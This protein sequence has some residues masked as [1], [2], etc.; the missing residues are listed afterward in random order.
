MIQLRPSKAA[1]WSVCAAQ[2]S[3]E[4]RTPEEPPSEEAKEGTCAAWVAD[5]VLR[6]DAHSCA[7][8]IRRSH[9]NGWLVGPEMADYVQGY[10]DLV[11]ADGGLTTTEQFVRLNDF[12]GGTL[13]SSTALASGTLKI[14]DLKYGMQL[15]EIFDNPQLL[16]YGGAEYKRLTEAGHVITAIELA[17]YQPRAFHH[18]GIYRPWRLTPQELWDH[19]VRLAT[20][21]QRCQESVPVATAGR[22]CALHHCRAR[23]SCQAFISSTYNAASVLAESTAQRQMTAK[24]LADFWLFLETAEKL[25]KSAKSAA[26]TEAETRMRKGE[27]VPGLFLKPR[28][29]NRK[30]KYPAETIKRFTGVDPTQ[31]QLVTPA[32]LERQGVPVAL[33]NAMSEQPSL[34]PKVDRMP[35]NYLA[36][37]FDK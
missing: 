8:M 28:A 36:K 9:A 31:P 23:L 1:L 10:V 24:E 13:D 14:R 21:G 5:C 29:G 33:V 7:D 25:I 12:I 19:C 17:I 11:C 20:A 2:P 34:A 6:G 35:P 27:H 4:S 16:I 15:V 30:F 32:E 37:V 3:F 18:Q 26:D 22:H